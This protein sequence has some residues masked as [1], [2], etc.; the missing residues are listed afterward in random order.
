MQINRRLPGESEEEAR[1]RIRQERGDYR[2]Q[3]EIASDR[4]DKA[5]QSQDRII[6]RLTVNN[7]DKKRGN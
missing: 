4:T 2:T 3:V 7:H 6:N 5:I 1:A